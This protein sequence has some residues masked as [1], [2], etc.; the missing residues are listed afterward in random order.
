M[1][2]SNKKKDQNY[3]SVVSPRRI[4]RENRK[5]TR[6]FEK[7]RERKHVDPSE[8]TTQMRDPNNVVGV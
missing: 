5:I 6:E 2:N 4:S 7:K 8:Y 1:F 3:I